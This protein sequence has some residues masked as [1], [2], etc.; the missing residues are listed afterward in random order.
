MKKWVQPTTL[1]FHGSPNEITVSAFCEFSIWEA[2]GKEGLL[3]QGFWLYASVWIPRSFCAA[4]RPA[5]PPSG[6][7]GPWEPLASNRLSPA[8]LEW[9]C[10]TAKTHRGSPCADRILSFFGNCTAA[11][12]LESSETVL[13]S[14]VQTMQ[15]RAALDK[16]SFRR[17]PASFGGKAKSNQREKT[18]SLW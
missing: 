4:Q 17:Q 3:G 14:L 2:G 18:G 16:N 8:G 13:S 5:L 7:P 6:P 12:P 11:E 15:T 9:S 1:L 10:G